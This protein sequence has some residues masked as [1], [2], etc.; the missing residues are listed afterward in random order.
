MFLPATR[1][2]ISI[3]VVLAIA[4]SAAFAQTRPASQKPQ[5]PQP[6]ATPPDDPQ[7]VETLKIDTDLVTVPLIA[8]D[9]SGMYITDLR[10]EEFTI[11]EDNVAQEI[12]F[13]GKVAAPFHVVLLL[14]T[15]SS[16]RDKLKEI[17]RAANAFVDQLQPLD[18]VKVI[19]FDDNVNDLNEFTSNRDLLHAAI[20]KTKS[21]Q[22]TKVYAAVEMAST[23]R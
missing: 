22:G 21:G 18:R 2:A 9:R 16:T 1:S 10:K 23:T 5:Q 11:T 17:Q 7:D 14:D 4:L 8:T 13:F 12:A 3:I 20:N 19:A 15:S 6:A